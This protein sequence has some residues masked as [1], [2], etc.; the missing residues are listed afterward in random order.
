MIS[1]RTSVLLTESTVTANVV[2]RLTGLE[3]FSTRGHIYDFALEDNI[4]SLKPKSIPL[5]ERLRLFN[6]SDLHILIATDSDQQ[7]ELIAAHVKALT[8]KATHQRV[9]IR[10]LT[11]EDIYTAI[12]RPT[13]F[14]EKL[15][16]E[17]AYL[18]VLNL[19][20]KEQ[21][22]GGSF[23]TTTGL[24]LSKSLLER[25]TSR[26]WT[27]HTVNVGGKELYTKLPPAM[28]TIHPIKVNKIQPCNTRAIATAA[29]FS[30][31]PNV[32]EQLQNAYENQEL[33]YV[34]TDST[35]LP[36]SNSLYSGHTGTDELNDAH[37]ALHNLTPYDSDLTRLVYKINESACTDNLHAVELESGFGATIAIDEPLPDHRITP[38]QDI[39]LHLATDPDTF[40]SVITSH[41]PKYRQFL[42]NGESLNHKLMDSLLLEGKRVMPDLIE[43]GVKRT[44]EL[45]AIETPQMQVQMRE[46][47]E[48]EQLAL[49]KPVKTGFALDMINP[50]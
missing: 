28:N 20:L 7:G 35:T 36:L 40:P 24:T 22:K 17:A 1:G 47:I 33:S 34:R 27:N 6:R 41:T 32:H 3:T 21:S 31:I 25:G 12:D 44:I 49:K 15:A 8:P 4:V 26:E 45:L 48:A 39:M 29:V 11:S 50:M 19:R 38:E 14:S 37:Y 43:H 16:T 46:A 42:Y 5:L 10:S 13:G 30:N 2:C 9:H 23:L 18:R